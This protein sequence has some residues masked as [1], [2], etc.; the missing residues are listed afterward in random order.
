MIPPEALA[1]LRAALP[2]DMPC[3]PDLYAERDPGLLEYTMLAEDKFPARF[4]DDDTK[5]Q[6]PRIDASSIDLSAHWQSV[7]PLLDRTRDLRLM[8]TLAKLA[9]TARQ[10]RA[11][12]DCV[13]VIAGWLEDFP[14]TVHPQI[15]QDTEARGNALKLLSSNVSV[16][17]P[18]EFTPLVKDR[19]QRGI[20]LRRIAVARGV[21]RPVVGEKVEDAAALVTALGRPENGAELIDSHATLLRLQSAVTRIIDACLLHPVQG[22]RPDLAPLQNRLSE[23]VALILE[24]RPDL[25]PAEPAADIVDSAADAPAPPS[26]AISLEST[27]QVGE[28]LRLVEQYFLRHEPSA[29]GLILVRQARELIGR[30][31]VEAIEKLVPTQAEAAR[32]EFAQNSGFALTMQQMRAR[33]HI[34]PVPAPVPEPPVS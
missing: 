28:V 9:A 20:T 23:I 1:A 10:L 6:T 24:V 2:G 29:P 3:G 16:L 15:V 22:F 18:L 26:A 25:A 13:D 34:D 21:R 11:L 17:F 32:I 8:G 19:R 12:A 4:F 14:E 33:S 7:A 27:A 30:P 31:L 5:A